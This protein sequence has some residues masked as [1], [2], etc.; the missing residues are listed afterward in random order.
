MRITTRMGIVLAAMAMASAGCTTRFGGTSAADRYAYP[1]SNI[2]PLGTVSAEFVK[3][4]M[5][6][7]L[8]ASEIKA[9]Q[10]KALAQAH[11]ANILINIREDVSMTIFPLLVPYGKI[12]YRVTGEAATMEVGEQVLN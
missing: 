5:M 4:G 10:Q 1:N 7:T 12:V 9:T 6:P 8:K 3:T 11:G 2:K